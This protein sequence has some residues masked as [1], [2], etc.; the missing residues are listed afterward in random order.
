MLVLNATCRQSDK[1]ALTSIACFYRNK[2]Y[3]RHS[4]DIT[5]YYLEARCPNPAHAHISL[6]LLLHVQDSL[7]MSTRNT[8]NH[9]SYRE[10][11]LLEDWEPEILTPLPLPG[12]Y[13]VLQFN[14]VA[15]AKHVGNSNLIKEFKKLQTNKYVAICAGVSATPHPL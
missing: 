6:L 11:K 5:T 10:S 9:R 8:S 3:G 4:T 2:G 12:E 14:P 15:M 7:A 1:I 13:V